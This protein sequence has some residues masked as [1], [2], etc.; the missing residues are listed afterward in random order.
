M[1]YR[2]YIHMRLLPLKSLLRHLFLPLYLKNIF[3]IFSY[4]KPATGIEPVNLFLTKEALYQ[5]SYAGNLFITQRQ[6]Q[7][8]W[9]GRRDLNPRHPAWKAEALPTE[10]LPQMVVGGGFDPPKAS[11]TDLQSVPFGRSGTPPYRA[12]RGTRTPDQLITNQPLYQLSY[13]GIS[14]YRL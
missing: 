4:L 5:L 14:I 12:S 11:P 2:P 3:K 6:I 10:L 7:N 1:P 8:I 9:S 13:A